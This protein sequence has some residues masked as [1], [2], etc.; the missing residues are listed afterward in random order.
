MDSKYGH[1][2]GVA[3]VARVGG[4]TRRAWSLLH[5]LLFASRLST[6]DAAVGVAISVPV[7]VPMGSRSTVGRKGRLGP[8]RLRIG[9]I[10]PR[11]PSAHDCIPVNEERLCKVLLDSDCLMV[12]VVVVGVVAE[13]TLEGVERKG[14]PAVIV[15]RLECGKSEEEDVLS[16]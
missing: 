14:V 7:G 5:L 4:L 6:V 3:V 10:R 16:R 8:L 2:Y 9:N 11:H 1:N 15:D 12:D 13:Q